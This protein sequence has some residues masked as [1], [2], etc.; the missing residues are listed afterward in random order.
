MK[1]I[2][3]GRDPGSNVFI[4]DPMISRRHALIRIHP[5][6]KMELVDMSSNGTFVNGVKL[7]SNVPVP[8]SRKDIISFAHVKQLDWTLVPNPLSWIKWAGIAVAAVAIL[9]GVLVAVNKCSSSSSRTIDDA[10]P[11]TENV[12]NAQDGTQGSTSGSSSSVGKEDGKDGQASS[13]EKAPANTD[14][15]TA[16]EQKPAESTSSDSWYKDELKKDAAKKAAAKAAAQKAAAGKKSTETKTTDTKA[17]DAKTS[18]EQKVQTKSP[19][20]AKRKTVI[21]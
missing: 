10:N 17:K 1:T 3:I 6:G 18:E 21:M 11:Q 15:A 16:S 2:T 12:D 13:A 9:I 19:E 4:D 5:T 14:K 20:P 7:A 8:I